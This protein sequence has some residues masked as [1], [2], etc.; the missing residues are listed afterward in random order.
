MLTVTVAALDRL[1]KKL[2]HMKAAQDAAM[3]FSRGDGGWRLH[4]DTARP[5]DTLFAH[6]DRTVLVLDEAVSEAMT[7]MT[8]DVK[9]TEAGPRLS[10]Q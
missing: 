3:R 4:L 9:D 1:S 5:A 7:D 2:A 6:E 8:L 10:L